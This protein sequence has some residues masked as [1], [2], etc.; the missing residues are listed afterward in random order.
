MHSCIIIITIQRFFS[1]SIIH[2]RYDWLYVCARF[3]IL[4]RRNLILMWIKCQWDVIICCNW[5]QF[6]DARWLNLSIMSVFSFIYWHQSST[7]WDFL[8]RMGF[9]LL[10]PFTIT[11]Q[12]SID[13]TFVKK[14][15]FRRKTRKMDGE[16]SKMIY[17]WQLKC[18]FHLLFIKKNV[19][20][21][22]QSLKMMQ[23]CSMW[24]WK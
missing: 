6:N 10:I 14:V 17:W 13:L 2:P 21:T 23:R 15:V 1:Y 5:I 20:V 19:D 24:K 7:E 3:F 9:S 12:D 4:D 16:Y 11:T 22:H 8:I 18:N